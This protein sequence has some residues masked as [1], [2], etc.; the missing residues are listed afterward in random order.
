MSLLDDEDILIGR[1]IKD[2]NMK[3]AI[4]DICKSIIGNELGKYADCNLAISE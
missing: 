3:E 2:S 1:A 4:K